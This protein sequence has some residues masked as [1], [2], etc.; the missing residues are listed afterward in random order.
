[1]S[2]PIPTLALAACLVVTAGAA[3]AAES[4]G[5]DSSVT[6]SASVDAIHQATFT[7]EHG[8]DAQWSQFML[9]AGVRKRFVPAFSAGFGLRYSY[10]GWRFRSPVA[11]DGAAPWQDLQSPGL[12]LELRQ[13]LS[14]TLLVGVSP[15]LQWAYAQGVGGS[16]GLVYGVVMSV[17]KAFSP[18]CVLG[19]GA[20]VSR[21]FYSVKTSPFVV[22]NWRLTDRWRIA[23]AF[24]GGYQGGAGV[25]LGYS[26]TRDVE[27]AFGGVYRSERYRLAQRTLSD[28]DVAD[29]G[30]IPLFGRVSCR[31]DAKT[32]IDVYGG[33][34]VNGVLKISDANGRELLRE[35]YTP[36]AA[37]AMTLARKF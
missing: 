26:P 30:S 34:M 25:E 22:V 23:N 24:P 17:A 2:R 19:G 4:S 32:R 35:T 15:W 21:Q 16:E 14:K 37:L 18:R 27:L 31:I 8:G 7:L 36:A 3:S 6:A 33:T 5:R 11:F 20:N 28:G 29:L 10:Q 1:M 13:A 12:N 9:N